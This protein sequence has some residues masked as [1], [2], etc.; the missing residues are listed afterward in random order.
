LYLDLPTVIA[1]PP[2]LDEEAKKQILDHNVANLFML[3][4]MGK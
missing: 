4:M 2:V 3:E 1:D